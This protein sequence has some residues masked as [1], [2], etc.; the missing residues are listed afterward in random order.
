MRSLLTILLFVPLVGF[1]Q[2]WQQQGQDIDSEA[3]GDQ[4]GISVSVNATGDRVAI[5]ANG[6]NG[7]SGIVN[8][9][10]GHVRIYFWNGTSWTQKGQDIDG[11]AAVDNSGYSVSMNAAGDRVAI[12]AIGNDGNANDA[13]H[14]RIYEWNGTL[15]TQQGQDIDGEAAGDFSGT[16]VSM[17]AAGDR[18]AIGAY[19]NDGNGIEAGH[20]RIYEWNGSIWTK[21][22]QDIDGEASGDRFG[23]SVSM[24]ASGDKVA[25]G[26][27]FND[28]NT[29]NFT[30]NRGHVRIYEWNGTNWT[31]KGQEIDGEAYGD[32]SG[33]SIS[34]NDAGDRMV[35]GAPYNNDNGNGNGFFSGHARIYS[36]NTELLDN[37]TVCDSTTWIDGVTYYSSTYNPTYILGSNSR[38]C[39]S[40]MRL[41][42]T[43]NYS[44][45][46]T[47]TLTEC[48]SY[49]WIDGNTYTSST[50]T[51]TY[52]LTN[53]AGCDSVVTLDLTIYNSDLVT[54]TLT[55]CDS[56]LWYA[57]NY[58]SSGTYNKVLTNIQGC[59]SS[60]TLNLTILNSSTGTATQNACNSYTWIDGNTYTSSTNTPTY[61]LTNAAG[62]D[63]IVT[64]NLSINSSITLHPNPTTGIVELQGI[65]G[66]FNVDV[67]DYAGKYL[68]S[69]NRSTIDLSDYSSGIYFLKMAC[70]DKTKELRVVKE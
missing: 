44:N 39:D 57:N 46:G 25:I 15:W 63:S 17:N 24:N 50:N 14:V 33:Y 28:A 9:Y 6:N 35:I 37:V 16:S 7:N 32:R 58:D 42:L 49:T 21:L 51:P 8:D 22:G 27:Y 47:E 19:E 52:T 66:S 54:E 4:F 13:G 31:Q 23:C 38:G 55:A 41:N 36:C 62:C 56:Y 59:D 68:Q 29:G 64:L 67:Y 70:G 45:T 40:V 30:D 10:R 5:G 20:A 1:S 53:T 26:A 11:E 65:N 18:V 43:V 34:M 2:Y 61:T 48:N 69:T 12:G 60:V 3:A